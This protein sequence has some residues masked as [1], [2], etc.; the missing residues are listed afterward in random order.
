LNTL[1]APL[2][3]LEPLTARHAPE[4]F[5]VLGDPA[6]YEFENEPPASEEWLERRYR[7]LEGR[8][9]PDG[10][11]QWLN[12]V[13][14]LPGGEAAGYVQATIHAS[15]EAS[16]AYELNSR[17]WR[18][19]IA[20]SAVR[21]ML[22]ELETTYS[23][24]VFLAILKVANYRSMAL[25]RSLGFTPAGESQAVLQPDPGETVMVK[26]AAAEV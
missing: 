25:L 4:M 10:T 17:Y 5:V 18:R 16:V 14:R 11:Q 6:I 3:T 7:F 24:R 20:G 12:W 26:T 1:R 19:G 8:A 15:G 9:S 22:A 21:V 23:V 13:V 2:C